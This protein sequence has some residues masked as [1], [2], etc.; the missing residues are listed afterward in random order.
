MAHARCRSTSWKNLSRCSR[1]HV[2]PERIGPNAL[3]ASRQERHLRKGLHLRR[4]HK[5][6][7]QYGPRWQE[8]R[9]ASQSN[10]LSELGNKRLKD[11]TTGLGMNG[12]ANS[13]GGRQQLRREVA[14]RGQGP[15]LLTNREGHKFAQKRWPAS[16][17][18]AGKGA[19]SRC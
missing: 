8:S 3:G 5:G 7:S 11:L 1:A 19:G 4:H 6:S 2:N 17:S 13:K 12:C 18:T 15:K 10:N 9:G 16:L 14:R